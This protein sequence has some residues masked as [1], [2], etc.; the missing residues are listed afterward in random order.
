[1]SLVQL[2]KPTPSEIDEICTILKKAPKIRTVEDT[3]S[4]IRL[5]KCLPV[6]NQLKFELLG[7][8]SDRLKIYNIKKETVICKQGYQG[9]CAYILLKG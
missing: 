3:T 8:L 2:E 1:M 7:E 6:F 9:I 4:L 5:L